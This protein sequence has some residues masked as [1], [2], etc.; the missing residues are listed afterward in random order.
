MKR[1]GFFGVL[2]GLFVAPVVAKEPAPQF[3]TETDNY[4]E[5][6]FTPSDKFVFPRD[7]HFYIGSPPHVGSLKVVGQGP[8][9]R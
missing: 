1:R 9:C 2:A 3:T 4:P 5:F 6:M 8:R 7:S